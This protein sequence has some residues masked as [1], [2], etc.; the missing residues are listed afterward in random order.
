QK[1]GP[2]IYIEEIEVASNKPS[3]RRNEIRIRG[4]KFDNVATTIPVSS[5]FDDGAPSIEFERIE[6]RAKVLV[7]FAL[8]QE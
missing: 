8:P 4:N 2:A 5:N 3:N 1:L 6:L 7:R